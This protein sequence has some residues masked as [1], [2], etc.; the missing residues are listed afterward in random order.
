MSKPERSLFRFVDLFREVKTKKSL[1]IKVI[2]SI[3]LLI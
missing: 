1:V 3:E 2:K